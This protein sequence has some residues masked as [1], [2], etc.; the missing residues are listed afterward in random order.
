[1]KYLV[2]LNLKAY[3]PL[4]QKW[5]ADR[6]WEVEQCES[7]GLSGRQDSEPV[8]WHCGDVRID[9]KHVREFFHLPK[10]GEKPWQMECFGVCVRGQDNAIEIHTG[11]SDVSGNN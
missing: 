3:N 7:L 10:P 9:T 8:I 5:R 2:R 4:T 1:M 6:L 11:P